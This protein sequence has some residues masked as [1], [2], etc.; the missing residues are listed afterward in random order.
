MTAGT[1][2]V[3]ICG[4]HVGG[5]SVGLGMVC[6]ADGQVG[7]VGTVGDAVVSEGVGHVGCA[8]VSDG[9]GHVDCAVVN[10]GVGHQVVGHQVVVQVGQIV[11]KGGVVG[12]GG[13]VIGGVM[14]GEFVNVDNEVVIIGQLVEPVSG[15]VMMDIVP[16]I[17]GVIIGA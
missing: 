10:E 8:V 6:V 17:G 13:A 3:F 4:H 11:V 2:V 12:P 15:G 9:V 14:I 5:V 1:T 7:I 16:L